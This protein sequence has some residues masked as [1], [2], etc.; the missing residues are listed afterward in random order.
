MHIPTLTATARN[1]LAVIAQVGTM[2]KKTASTSGCRL[3]CS[4]SELRGKIRIPGISPTSTRSFM[5]SLLGRCSN[6]T[7]SGHTYPFT[8]TPYLYFRRL[9]HSSG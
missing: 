2:E 8:L 9:E 4:H 6:V 5:Q 3:E 1:V 7:S